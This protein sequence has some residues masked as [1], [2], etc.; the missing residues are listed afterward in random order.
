MAQATG[1]CALKLQV[2]LQELCLFLAEEDNQGKTLFDQD[3]VFHMTCEVQKLRASGELQNRPVLLGYKEESRL[4]INASNLQ[5]EP[6]PADQE[7]KVDDSA[8]KEFGFGYAMARFLEDAMARFLEV[9][10]SMVKSAFADMTA[11][12]SQ[13]P[14][15]DSKTVP[16]VPLKASVSIG[17]TEDETTRKL[18]GGAADAS[19]GVV[20]SKESHDEPALRGEKKDETQKG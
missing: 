14:E 16:V 8:F 15:K 3:A 12:K 10:A 19:G 13:L 2:M 6:K 9:A 4:R 5:V 18:R 1:F 11:D 17:G 7:G 20:P